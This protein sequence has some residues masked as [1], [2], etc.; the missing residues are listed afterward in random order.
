[1][2][3]RGKE[4]TILNHHRTSKWGSLSAGPSCL[5]RLHQY[6]PCKIS[7]IIIYTI[8]YR[9]RPIKSSSKPLVAAM[10]ECGFRL[11]LR[12]D[13]ITSR[14]HS[15]IPDPQVR[16]RLLLRCSTS[17]LPAVPSVASIAPSSVPSS[18]SLAVCSAIM[19]AW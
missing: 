2:L 11:R 1:M 9:S 5:T 7:Y 18:S 13:K 6:L 10:L 4:L 14:H 12:F 19:A 8:I 15:I 17:S 16:S 3:P